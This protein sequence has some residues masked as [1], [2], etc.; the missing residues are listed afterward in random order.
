[1]A[2]NVVQVQRSKQ[3]HRSKFTVTGGNVAKVVVATSDAGFLV[4]IFAFGLD[5]D[6]SVL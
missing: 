5:C 6:K 2:H 4:K 1:M 3:G